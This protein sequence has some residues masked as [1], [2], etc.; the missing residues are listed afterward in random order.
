MVSASIA[1]RAADACDPALV[2]CYTD[3]SQPLSEQC[4]STAMHVHVHM[5][6]GMVP[7]RRGMLP[8]GP[9]P[10]PSST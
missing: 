4:A 6:V 10:S 1:K 7:S 3:D 9:L 2:L 8:V 5:V